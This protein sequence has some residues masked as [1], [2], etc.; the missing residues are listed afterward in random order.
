MDAGAEGP[1]SKGLKALCDS[2]T[3]DP[4]TLSLEPR[5]APKHEEGPTTVFSKD[6]SLTTGGAVRHSVILDERKSKCPQQQRI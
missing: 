5:M 1:F 3:S 4:T 2:G 6:Q